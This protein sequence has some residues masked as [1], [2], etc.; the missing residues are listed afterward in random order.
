[1]NIKDKRSTTAGYTILEENINKYMQQSYQAGFFS[2]LCRHVTLAEGSVCALS[3]SAPSTNIT[4]STGRHLHQTFL[5]T[6]VIN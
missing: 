3:D 4:G 2:V 1:M 5:V 6:S